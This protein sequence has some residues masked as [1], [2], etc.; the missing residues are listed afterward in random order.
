MPRFVKVML[1]FSYNLVGEKC[2]KVCGRTFIPPAQIVGMGLVHPI[3]TTGRVEGIRSVA[4]ISD[5]PGDLDAPGVIGSFST[6]DT[7]N[8]GNI[9]APDAIDNPGTS[10]TPETSGAVGTSGALGVDP[11][12]TDPSLEAAGHGWSTWTSLGQAC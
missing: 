10:S 4:D 5:T 9:D 12:F 2:D 11:R 6:S 8:P 3:H 1:C 7:G